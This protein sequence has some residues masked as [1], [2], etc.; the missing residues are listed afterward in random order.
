MTPEEYK[1]FIASLT[2]EEVDELLRLKKLV[3]DLLFGSK[4]TIVLD[5]SLSDEEIDEAISAFQMLLTSNVGPCE[6]E[7]KKGTTVIFKRI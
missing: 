5:P 2:V 7:V 6:F 3:G 4:A 1:R